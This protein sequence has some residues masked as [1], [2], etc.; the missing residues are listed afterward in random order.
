MINA[1][2]QS[3]R[4]ILSFP[5][6]HPC[7]GV[8]PAAL[9]AS[10]ISLSQTIC[11]FQ[12]EFFPTQRRN[13]REIIRQLGI[14]L[15]FLEEIRDR[16]VPVRDSVAL[17]FS[18]LHLT[19]QKIHFLLSDCTRD[20]ARL[21]MLMK[22]EHVAT[23]F[24]VLTR[25]LA[26]ALDILPLSSI[27]IC[28]EV[29]EVVEL[30]AKQAQKVRLELDPHDELATKQVL[31]VL[32][33]FDRGKEPNLSTVKRTLSY[34]GI[35]NWNDCNKEI[36]FLEDEINFTYSEGDEREVPFL[37][38]LVG[39]LC[40]CRVVIFETLDFQQT[41]T[42]PSEMRYSTEMIN[43]INPQDF[44]CPISLQL[45]TDP[46]TVSTGQTYDRASIQKWLQ[47]GN[48]TCPKT[49]EKLAN[50][51]L[52][53][54]TT[55][56]KLIHQF[57][58]DNRVSAAKSGHRSR[59]ITRTIVPG[60]TASAHA[61]QFLSWFI[62]RRLVFG[63]DEQKNKAAYEI[64][65]LARS[66][67]FNRACLVEVGTVPSLINLLDSDDKSTQENAISALLKLAKHTNGQ[68]T[69][70]ESD[71]LTPIL[72]VLKNGITL[73]ARQTAAA[74]IFYLSST[75]ENRKI[76]GENPEVIP[77]LVELIKEETTAFGK[78]NAIVAI[79]GLLL[80]PQN[81]QKVLDADTVPTLVSILA[82]SEK[83]DLT[84]D[85]LAVLA[86][87]AENLEG[88]NAMSKACALPLILG[89]LQ[90]VTRRA[91]KEHCVAILMSMCMHIGE[92]VVGVLAKDPSLMPWLYSLLTDGTSH[93]AKK[94]RSL[95]RVLQEFNETRT[96]RWVGS[97]VVPERSLHIW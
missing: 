24:R 51:E 63:T 59:D 50:T 8:S 41:A 29:K 45:M 79:F 26:T 13:S 60:S 49:G 11:S 86:A 48:R 1:S 31:S 5:A 87:L 35:Q 57:C 2:N 77:A 96:S 73:E 21:W 74:V 78:K 56:R 27:E 15:L 47:A 67:I 95:I 39:Y 3:G 4:R 85:C 23:Q 37:S 71:G 33:Q 7:E 55:L 18:E 6:V 80:L 81:H 61:M 30:V 38:S 40:Y 36:K 90:T 72:V 82:S 54:N 66:N 69:I 20:G 9:L 14:I 75:R 89:M 88:A 84:T 76:I 93:A 83:S 62:A 92:E 91:E 42:D 46:V 53:P 97:S 94:A 12:S 65:V 58:A 64:R 34:L 25:A 70:M 10:L 28:D 52:L 19:L 22:S 16:G 43:F 17:C 32:N 68:K 44:R